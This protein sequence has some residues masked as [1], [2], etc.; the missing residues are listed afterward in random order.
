MPII[1]IR[2]Y[3]KR[4]GNKEGTGSGVDREREG[5]VCTHLCSG[6]LLVFLPIPPSSFLLAP[7]S[8]S[9]DPLRG[10]SPCPRVPE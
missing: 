6:V 9:G 3:K 2:Y 10:P 8:S 5:R 1:T 7:P 4:A